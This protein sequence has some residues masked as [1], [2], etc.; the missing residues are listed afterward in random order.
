MWYSIIDI[1]LNGK[2][3]FNKKISKTNKLEKKVIT[4]NNQN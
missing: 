2:F 3:R 4:I 1:V